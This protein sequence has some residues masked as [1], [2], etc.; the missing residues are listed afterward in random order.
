MVKKAKQYSPKKISS[1]KVFVSAYRKARTSLYK[2]KE[3]VKYR[4]RFLHHNPLCYACGAKACVVD[5]IVAA[6]LDENLFKNVTN[7]LPLCKS[8]HNA[9]TTLFDK[10]DPPKTEDKMVWLQ[11][12]RNDTGTKVRVKVLDKYT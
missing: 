10:Y 9:I 6:K 1:G 7:H 8:C 5:H 4:F 11:K 3:W 12:K 2:T